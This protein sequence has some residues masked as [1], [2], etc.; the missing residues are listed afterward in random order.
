[1]HDELLFAVIRLIHILAGVLWVGAAVM[2]A[3]F[4]GPAA[5]DAG[6]AGG[7]VMDQLIRVRKL[8]AYMASVAGSTVLAGLILMWM[9]ASATDGGWMRTASGKLFMWG[10]LV[11]IIGFVWGM[12][13]ATRLA[14]RM[15]ARA[16][17]MAAAGR[18]PTPEEQAELRQG[19]ARL[20]FHT[21]GAA[22]VL[23][24]AAAMM[25]LARYV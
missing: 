11:A 22:I 7:A 10:A 9:H 18:P 6:P 2:L 15:T 4:V 12:V 21:R 1:M 17:A 13:M 20:S 24:L 16:S 14:K 5:G 3:F 8:P 25:A 23:I 19:F